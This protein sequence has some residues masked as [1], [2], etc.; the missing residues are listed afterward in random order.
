MSNETFELTNEYISQILEDQEI[1]SMIMEESMLEEEEILLHKKLGTLDKLED[2][3]QTIEYIISTDKFLYMEDDITT[4]AN[5][6]RIYEFGIRI[7]DLNG[8]FYGEQVGD[9]GRPST[10]FSDDE[11]VLYEELSKY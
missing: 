1:Y 11:N 5:S 3:I 7:H 4:N 10:L 9:L 6:E 8:I 2:L